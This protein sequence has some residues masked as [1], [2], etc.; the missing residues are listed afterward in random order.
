M[1]LTNKN[2]NFSLIARSGQCFRMEEVHDAA[3]PFPP[4]AQWRV[5]AGREQ[6]V[7][8]MVGQDTYDL[9]CPPDRFPFWETYFD[10]SGP[11]DAAYQALPRED[12]YLLRCADFCRGLRILR[13]DPFETL[14][15]FILS[16]RKS[17][18]AIRQ[19]VERLCESF[20]EKTEAGYLFPTP[21]ALAGCPPEALRACGLG[22][23]A[24]YVS[25]T[26]RM[27]DTFPLPEADTDLPDDELLDLLCA[28]PGVGVKVASCV[29][30]FAYHRLAVA[31]VDVW[32]QKVIDAHYA[33]VNPFP[34]LGSY[35]GLYQ[36]YM[37]CEA[38][39]NVTSS[40]APQCRSDTD[41]CG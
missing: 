37:F 23:R 27:I 16:Q 2:L 6:L 20:G 41:R 3:D 1:I 5:L 10:L 29:A 36:Q 40:P 38:R 13:Q 31:P 26:A 14:I 33:G 4:S 11:Y 30:L 15:S 35:A 8:R 22:Y 9:N 34:T 17:I 28:F 39:L 19:C 18:P 24:P 12:S 21:Q 32:I 7:I 25:Q